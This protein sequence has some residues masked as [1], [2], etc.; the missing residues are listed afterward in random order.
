MLAPSEM[1]SSSGNI[2]MAG[3]DS[4]NERKYERKGKCDAHGG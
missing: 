2:G 1:M 4:E 3:R